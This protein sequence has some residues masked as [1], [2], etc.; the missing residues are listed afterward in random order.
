MLVE[1]RGLLALDQPLLEVDVLWCQPPGRWPEAAR[2]C[3][4]PHST[5]AWR[6]GCRVQ[7]L[8]TRHSGDLEAD[9]SQSLLL[10]D[11]PRLLVAVAV[12]GAID[13]D[14]S[15]VVLVDE[16]DLPESPAADSSMTSASRWS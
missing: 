11:V 4:S 6:E 13:L 2:Q 8:S 3:P 7:R 15:G 14:R 16:I 12:I 9:L 5:Q 10:G 1:E